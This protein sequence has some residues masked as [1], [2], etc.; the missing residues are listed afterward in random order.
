M[1]HAL[2]DNVN[3]DRIL[4]HKI[5]MNYQHFTFFPNRMVDPLLITEIR[6]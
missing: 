1:C 4:C 2:P 5:V 6:D 3:V